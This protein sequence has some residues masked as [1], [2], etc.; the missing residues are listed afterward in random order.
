[1]ASQ[2]RMPLPSAAPL[3]EPAVATAPAD[4]GNAARAE[5]VQQAGFGVGDAAEVAAG[6]LISIPVDLYHGAGHL[7]DYVNP[8][9]NES[10]GD[11]LA[12]DQRAGEL[13]YSLLSNAPSLMDIA[14]KAIVEVY[15][16]DRIPAE[17]Q[18][19]IQA[20]VGDLAAGQ[21]TRTVVRYIASDRLARIVARLTT[22]ALAG[23]V[24]ARLLA[25]LGIS[26]AAVGSGVGS[27]LGVV[28]TAGLVE[29]AQMGSQR[30]K[31]EI[32]LLYQALSPNNLDLL[33]FLVADSIDELERDFQNQ[34]REMVGLPP[35]EAERAAPGPDP[36]MLD[37]MMI[38]P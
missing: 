22:K 11:L 36:G 24:A 30:L 3:V 29:Q 25:R 1:M 16:A 17:L 5:E 18:S 4:V 26:A 34:L 8:F 32:P 21:G 2:Q 13:L 33:W 31:N 15:F 19:A 28:S 35:A 14:M 10:A 12:E 20:Q 23:A 9:D 37:G 7:L 38:A 27:A 6:A